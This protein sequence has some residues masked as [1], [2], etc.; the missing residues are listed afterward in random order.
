MKNTHSSF[1]SVTSAIVF[2]L[3]LTAIANGCSSSAGTGS[4]N[5]GSAAS[6]FPPSKKLSEITDADA[7]AVCAASASRPSPLTAEE[8][9]RLGCAFA[10]AFSTIGA[11]TDAE[12][13]TKCQT[14]FDKCL[15]EPEKPATATDCSMEKVPSSFKT[16]QAT[17]AEYDACTAEQIPA[18]KAAAAN[19]CKGIKVTKGDAPP[20]PKEPLTPACAALDAKCPELNK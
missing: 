8:S 14:A 18:F 2:G 9:K 13:L 11:T 7:Q 10:A 16:C 17:V 1:R 12:A 15:T 6:G 3:S 19:G 20:P 5:G 4:T